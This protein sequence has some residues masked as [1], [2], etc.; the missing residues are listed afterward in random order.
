MGC[1]RH[2]GF[3]IWEML[4]FLVDIFRFGFYNN[5][6][7]FCVDGQVWSIILY[8]AMKFLAIILYRFANAMMIIYH[9]DLIYCICYHILLSR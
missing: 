3:Y 4:H 5:D 7:I 9:A 1:S 6:V 8:C 2:D